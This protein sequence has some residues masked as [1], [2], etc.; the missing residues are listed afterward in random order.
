MIDAR[1]AGTHERNV[2]DAAE[3][4]PVIDG[5]G[6]EDTAEDASV[7]DFG[8]SGGIV[9]VVPLAVG[10]IVEHVAREGVG[11]GGALGVGFV[12]AVCVEVAGE[13]AGCFGGAGGGD[14]AVGGGFEVCVF[15][16]D[17]L[18]D[19]DFE[20]VFVFEGHDANGVADPEAF[21][22]V[23][24]AF[25]V[26]CRVGPSAFEA[27]GL[28]DGD[29]FECFHAVEDRLVP[30]IVGEAIHGFDV[31]GKRPDAVERNG[32]VLPGETLVVAIWIRYMFDAKTRGLGAIFLLYF[33]QDVFDSELLFRGL[34]DYTT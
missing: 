7:V 21:G 27:A 13:E 18:D 1:P 20:D 31:K 4:A 33:L 8:D 30:G 24:E 22:A 28:G 25:G 17:F 2:I 34:C 10:A 29:G 32:S 6:F 5:I 16:G 9:D 26:E 15:C 23:E 3:R 14:F 19:E 11:G 12:V